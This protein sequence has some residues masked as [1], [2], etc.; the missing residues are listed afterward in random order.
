MADDLKL[1]T[2]WN[3]HLSVYF[4]QWNAQWVVKLIL[5]SINSPFKKTYEFFVSSIIS[6][7]N[8]TSSRLH[9]T[10]IDYDYF[11]LIKDYD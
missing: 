7:A 1:K 2:I 11:P 6:G 4:S 10:T 9:K 3:E 8:Q 5:E